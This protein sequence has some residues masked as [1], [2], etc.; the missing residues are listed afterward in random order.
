[1]ILVEDFNNK[2]NLNKKISKNNVLTSKNKYANVNEPN[3]GWGGGNKPIIFFIDFGLGFISH[4][5]EDKAVDIHLLN[6]AIEAKHF[7]FST[8]LKRAFLRG[9]KSKSKDFLK[10]MERL[11]AVEK[12]GRYKERY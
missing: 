8:Q 2:S 1:M 11:K 5:I 3:M 6:E 4:K 10:I 9:Y 12:R 7:K